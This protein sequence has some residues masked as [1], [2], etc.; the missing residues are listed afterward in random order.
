M[1]G[2]DADDIAQARPTIVSSLRLSGD[3]GKSYI[4]QASTNLSSG[5]WTPVV[6]EY[7]PTAAHS[8]TPTSTWAI[9]TA[10]FS[11]PCSNHD[12]ISLPIHP[13]AA[14]APRAGHAR[15]HQRAVV[16]GRNIV[17][18]SLR[19]CWRAALILSSCRYLVMWAIDAPAN[20]GGTAAF[21]NTPGCRAGYRHRRADEWLQSE[22]RKVFASTI[23]SEED[24]AAS[25]HAQLLLG[26]DA[27]PVTAI[28]WRAGRAIWR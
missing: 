5:G 22:C 23:R 11:A 16:A 13:V 28:H 17:W 24:W 18:S 9:S 19:T 12:K 1:V 7:L 20:S 3:P 10:D 6:D 14:Q 2:V 27:S 25:Y 26:P 4:I 8:I 21:P 15:D